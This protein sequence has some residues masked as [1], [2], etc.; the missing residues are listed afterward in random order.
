MP[1]V[2]CGSRTISCTGSRPTATGSGFRSAWSAPG[3]AAPGTCTVTHDI[4]HPARARLFSKV[5]NEC[6][7]LARFSTG[8]NGGPGPDDH[9]TRAGNLF[10]RPS[11]T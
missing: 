7:L 5:G 10:R 4:T 9:Y 1:A 11:A 8:D 6:K 3:A 2:R